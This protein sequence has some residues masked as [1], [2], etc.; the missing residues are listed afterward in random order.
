[1]QRKEDVL[2]LGELGVR[3]PVPAVCLA[4]LLCAPEV[5]T[6]PLLFPTEA[7]SGRISSLICVLS[8]QHLFVLCPVSLVLWPS[9]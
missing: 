2:E 6:A 8:P 1:M 7:G 3:G 5:L 9:H 4:D